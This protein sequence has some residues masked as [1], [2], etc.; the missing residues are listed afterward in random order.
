MLQKL[1]LSQILEITKGSCENSCPEVLISQIAID[2]RQVL[3]PSSTLFIALRGAKADGAAFIPEL[4]ASGVKVFVVP[5]DFSSEIA[6]GTWM[7]KVPDTRKALQDLARFERNQFQKPVVSVT[8]SNGKTIVKEWL[9]QILTQTYAVAKSPKSYNSQVGVPLSIFGIE[10]YHQV[11]IL[12]AGISKR[13]EMDALK[14]MIQPSLGVFTNIGTAHQEG[15]A[16][17]EEKLNEK[18]SLFKDSELVIYCKDQ[19]YVA[20]AMEREY[21]ADKLIAWSDLPGSDYCRSIKK[22]LDSSRII[23]LKNDLSTYT[24][25]VPFTDLASL[26]NITH[27]IIAAITLGQ[28]TEAIQAGIQNLKPVEMRLTLKAGVND[29]LLI[30]DTYNNDLAGLKV[31]LDFMQQQRP[32]KRRVLILSDFL[33]Q[34]DPNP[35]YREVAELADRYA[36]DLVIGVG[37]QI[38]LLEK[39]LNAKFLQFETTAQLMNQLNPDS[40]QNDLILITGARVFGFEEVVNRLQQMVH[41]TTLEINLNSLTHNYNFFKKLIS[42][43]TKVMI[44]VKAFAYGGGAVEIANLVQ[45]MGADYLGVAFSDEGIALRKQGITLPIMVLNPMMESFALCSEYDLE[46]VVFSLEFFQNLATW[47]STHQKQMK[48][49]LDLDTGMHRLGF[50]PKHISAL[51]L[52]IAENP[53]LEIAS[54]YTHLVGADEQVHREFTL[55]QLH[56]FER[57]KDQILG[58]LSYRPLI[59]ALNSAG[60]VA[61]PEWQFD[62]VRMGIGLYGVDLTG[63]YNSNLRTISTLKTTVS[64][65]KEIKAGETVGYSRMGKLEAGGK[66][67]T[68]AIGYAD[69]YDRRFGNGKG[70]VLIHGQKAPLVGNVCMDMCMVDVTGLDVKTGDVAVIYGEKIPLI[71]LAKLIG[72]IPY[73]LHTNIST[74]VKRVYYLD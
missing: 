46:P 67:A 22:E 70:Y 34:G 19:E 39:Q 25:Q 53:Q 11:A 40:F 6:P 73:E 60:I 12:E 74:R 61:F 7:I 17:L 37:T 49:H 26:E 14:E 32:K 43:Q 2:S 66:I 33:Q 8:G 5:A 64:Q 57:M 15:F 51:N 59:H 69:G 35:L 54:I 27:V 18:V 65:V 23:L 29:S 58:N 72:T 71:E 56:T 47:C 55:H 13:G 1:S 52:L 31:A 50:E 21:P 20:G 28:P 16:S 63:N 36:I 3:N 68:L 42:P 45:T 10:E 44:M 41:G 4:I 30:D 38:S 48:I 62:M 24:F 9:G